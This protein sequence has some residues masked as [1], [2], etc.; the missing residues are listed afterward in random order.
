MADENQNKAVTTQEQNKKALEP[1]KQAVSDGMKKFQMIANPETAK[2]EAGFAAQIMESSTALQAIAKT[3]N[4]FASIVNAIINVARMRITLNP[5]MKQAY[6][7]PRKNMCVLEPSWMGLSK[8]LTDGGD[9]EYV[10]AAIVYEDEEFVFDVTNT[11]HKP[12]YPDTEEENNQRKM[13]GALSCAHLKSGKRVYEFIPTWELKKIEKMSAGGFAYTGWRTEMYKKAVIRRHYKSLPKG[14]NAEVINEVLKQEEDMFK[15]PQNDAS[16]DV[17]GESM[18]EEA[19]Y[20][21]VK[22]KEP[23]GILKLEEGKTQAEAQ[24]GTAEEEPKADKPKV[25]PSLKD[26]TKKDKGKNDPPPSDKLFS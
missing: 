4:G 2:I 19:S 23:E 6:L 20:E 13:I 22:E 21:E 11:V 7:I 26:A 25:T 24:G 9:V 3:P 8:I 14:N 16:G 1:W 18:T 15:K 10:S 5:S 12:K 17:F